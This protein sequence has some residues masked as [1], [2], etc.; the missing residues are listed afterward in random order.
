MYIYIYIAIYSIAIMPISVEIY[1]HVHII[2]M[3]PL[4][5]SAFKHYYRKLREECVREPIC[6]TQKRLS[7]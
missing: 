7:E 3:Y 4:S 6:Q 2:L 5:Y 1:I